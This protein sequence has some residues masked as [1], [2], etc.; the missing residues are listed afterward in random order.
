MRLTKVLVCTVYLMS[1]N[2]IASESYQVKVVY[3]EPVNATEKKIKNAL[4]KVD[5]VSSV[6]D[7]ING[8]YRLPSTLSFQFGAEDGPLYDSELNTIDIPYEFFLEVENRFV[9]AQG[10]Q[11]NDSSLNKTKHAITHTLLHEFAH[12][13]IY[14]FEL[15][16]LGKEEDAADALASILLLEYFENGKDTVL[17]AASLFKL[18][19]LDIMTFEDEDFSGEHSLD[20]QRYFATLCLIYGSDPEKNSELINGNAF[21]SERAELC[22]EEYQSLSDSWHALLQPFTRS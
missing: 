19:S 16:V 9:E 13:A 18:E 15:P 10:Q 3:L 22:I 5:A 4:Q 7:F 1:C 17:S 11:P 14:T 2:G 21:S 12:A 8:T 20:I 6:V